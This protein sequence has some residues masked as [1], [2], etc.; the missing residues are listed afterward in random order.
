MVSVATQFPIRVDGF[1]QVSESQEQMDADPNEAIDEI[2][3]STAENHSKL[4][5]SSGLLLN[6]PKSKAKASSLLLRRQQSLKVPWT[7]LETN[8]L[9]RGI[10]MFGC[11][12]W[13]SVLEYGKNVF[14]PKRTAVDLKDKYRNLKKHE[15]IDSF[16]T[17]PEDPF[18]FQPNDKF[19]ERNELLQESGPS[20]SLDHSMK[21]SPADPI[22]NSNP[23]SVQWSLRSSP[24]LKRCYIADTD[25]E[26]EQ[27][28][29]QP[30]ENENL[31]NNQNSLLLN[32]ESSQ[33]VS[34]DS[35]E[36]SSQNTRSPLT[37]LASSK[38][39]NIQTSSSRKEPPKNAGCKAAPGS[40]VRFQETLRMPWSETEIDKLK[41]GI[42]M[43]GCGNWVSILS[44][45]KDVFHHK[46]RPVDLKDKYRNLKKLNLI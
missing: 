15:L 40:I 28:L 34:N 37:R 35:Q 42:Q 18:D 30:K 31:S 21:G 24:R 4:S 14:H 33:V 16:V 43:Y 5:P 46:R 8:K 32:Q 11:G 3:K 45:G 25:S 2:E 38:N 6:C 39:E 22:S 27:E 17:L 36:G 26:S 20:T 44:Y 9:K 12:N 23:Q 1:C 41:S 7:A 19:V 13:E 10:E 29:Q